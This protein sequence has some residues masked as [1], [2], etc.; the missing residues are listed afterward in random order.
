MA[1]HGVCDRGKIFV[2]EVEWETSVDVDHF[3]VAFI[4]TRRRKEKDLDAPSLGS[5]YSLHSFLK[6]LSV[7]VHDACVVW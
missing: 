1:V 2:V 3:T 5:Y 6:F 7:Y 4:R